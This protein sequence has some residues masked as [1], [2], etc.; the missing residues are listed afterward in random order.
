MSLFGTSG[1]RGVFGQDLTLELCH[2]VA[3]SLGTSL[4]AGARVCLARDS[5]ISG[6]AIRDCFLDGLVSCGVEAADLGILPT[7]AV[8][9]LTREWG[10][11]A[12]VM[13]TASHNPPEFNGIKLFNHDSLGYSPSQEL[14]IESVYL[15][16][17]F[18]RGQG[19]FYGSE[20]DA[21]E[22]Y[23]T[24]IQAR[25]G[26]TQ[27]RSPLGIVVDPGNG[28]ASRFASKV[29]A[30]MGL[31]TLPMN[32]APDGSFPR[33]NPEPREDTLQGTIAYLRECGADLAV[34]FD[35]D[36]DRVV[37]CDEKGFL[38]FN[39]GIA[40]I[41]RCV[42][43]KSGRRTVASTVESG[44]LLDFATQDLGAEI[45]RGKVGDVHVAYLAREKDAAIGVEQVGVYVFPDVGYYP[46]S[47]VATLA[48]LEDLTN[49]RQI[50]DFFDGIP[51]LLFKKGK[52]AC[53]NAIK[54]AAMER[55]IGESSHF[56]AEKV[57][58]LDGL[59]LEFGQSWMLIRASGT[60][61]A[62]RVLAES[63]SDREA[64]ALLS[65][66]IRTVEQAVSEVVR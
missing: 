3:K 9:L 49:P 57:N 16:K 45:V 52:I 54:A 6:P 34:C 62:I 35:G 56:A 12:G 39:E 1:V 59:R 43:Q 20:K 58:D 41:S 14:E 26:L 48:L 64:E 23:L 13:V 2:D 50:R 10:F 25:L 66:G 24:A 30:G 47:I 17:Q 18:R 51:R 53:P 44:R 7:P 61:P 27:I 38:G 11:D 42:L 15:G 8:A 28:A 40:Y 33:R 65:Q 4:P 21:V 60:E 31:H 5:R 37:F 36:A 46:D 22:G 29:F 19:G 55:V 63:T 32:D